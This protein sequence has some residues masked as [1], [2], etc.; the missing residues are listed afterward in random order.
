MKKIF[1]LSI[2]LLGSATSLSADTQWCTNFRG[3]NVDQVCHEACGKSSVWT[4]NVNM[5][6]DFWKCE[7]KGEGQWQCGT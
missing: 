3:S 7:C 2:F 6:D 4:R 1:I 5:D